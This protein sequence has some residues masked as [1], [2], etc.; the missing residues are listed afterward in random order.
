MS[1]KAWKRPWLLY[2]LDKLEALAETVDTETLWNRL[3]LKPRLV[4]RW[5]NDTLARERGVVTKQDGRLIWNT[6]LL[7][8]WAIACLGLKPS[9]YQQRKASNPEGKAFITPEEAREALN[10]PENYNFWEGQSPEETES[11]DE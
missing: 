7:R 8:L 9:K 10:I 4:A 5:A 1:V 3:K 11:A 2:R 6:K